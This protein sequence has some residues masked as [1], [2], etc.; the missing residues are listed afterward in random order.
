MRNPLSLHSGLGSPLFLS[1]V[2]VALSLPTGPNYGLSPYGFQNH[3]FQNHDFQNHDFQNHDFQNHGFQNHGFQ[4]HDFQNHDFQ[5]HDFQNHDF[6]NHDFQNQN[7]NQWPPSSLQSVV[8]QQGPNVPQH[9][10]PQQHLRP[11][12]NAPQLAQNPPGFSSTSRI[13]PDEEWDRFF[14]D[15]ALKSSPRRESLIPPSLP[16]SLARDGRISDEG[17]SSSDTRYRYKTPDGFQ[18]HGFQDHGFQN[19][20]FQNYDFHSQNPNQWPPSSLQSVLPQQD[21]NVPQHQFPQQHLRPSG[22]AP[23]LAQNPPGFS[24]TSRILPDEEWD[25]FFRD[26]ALKSSP[27]RESLIPPPLPPSHAG[28]YPSSSEARGFL[29]PGPSYNHAVELRQNAEGA[30]QRQNEPDVPPHGS[31]ATAMHNRVSNEGASSSRKIYTTP[32]ELEKY[33]QNRQKF[34]QE[35]EA[36]LKFRYSASPW[37]DVPALIRDHR[38]NTHF[39]DA[40]DSVIFNDIN[41]KIFGGKLMKVDVSKLQPQTLQNQHRAIYQPS[42]VLPFVTLK[43]QLME[44][45]AAFIDV[46]RMTVHQIRYR[47]NQ[48]PSVERSLKGKTLYNFWG[49][50]ENSKSGSRRIVI[51]YG[52]GYV[53]P[54]H[55]EAVNNHLKAMTRGAEAAAHFH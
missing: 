2:P 4:N 18:D 40:T 26:S 36:L 22:N 14:R 10:L 16:S 39:H 6:Q 45:G 11:S 42:R 17:A 15:S 54:G 37:E 1:L 13:L 50:P 27:R 23:Q 12:G 35:P 33:G 19:H 20:D 32:E 8:T 21:S 49:I 44:G 55:F 47:M 53:E 46:V 52:M 24:S 9:G 41:T 28:S 3:G 5:N 48:A 29:E 31:A 51:H 7:L 38:G 34:V 30:L 25:R 43:P